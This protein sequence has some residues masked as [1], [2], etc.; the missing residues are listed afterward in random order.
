MS[1]W[2]L[3]DIFTLIFTRTTSLGP[4]FIGH[5]MAIV[6]QKIIESVIVLLR[7]HKG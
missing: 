3:T 1:P 2:K 5:K 4:L 7:M 6:T